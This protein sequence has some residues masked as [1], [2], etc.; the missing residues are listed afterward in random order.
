MQSI[1][2]R[3][4]CKH[5]AVTSK[6]KSL[7]CGN[8]S[9][10]L[11]PTQTACCSAV[12]SCSIN[13]HWYDGTYYKETQ[14]TLRNSQVFGV[15]CFLVCRISFIAGQVRKYDQCRMIWKLLNNGNL[16]VR[17][18]NILDEN[19]KFADGCQVLWGYIF[20]VFTVT[21]FYLFNGHIYISLNIIGMLLYFRNTIQKVNAIYRFTTSRKICQ[22][23]FFFC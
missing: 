17:F 11:P 19:K 23:L 8:Q 6:W 1:N 12:G 4:A 3:G 5:Q 9:V 16:K 7:V 18:R 21:V 13:N 2:M 10:W 14:S 22:I 15:I 20:S